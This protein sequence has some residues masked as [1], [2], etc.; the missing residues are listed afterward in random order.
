MW[1]LSKDVCFFFIMVTVSKDMLKSSCYN[2]EGISSKSSLSPNL[3]DVL[4]QIALFL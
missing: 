4:T 1:N 3:N 2:K